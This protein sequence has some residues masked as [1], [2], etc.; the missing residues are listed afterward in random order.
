MRYSILAVYFEIFKGKLKSFQTTRF[1]IGFLWA[2]KPLHPWYTFFI[3]FLYSKGIKRKKKSKTFFP[4]AQSV[5]GSV[6]A[7]NF[8]KACSK[9]YFLHDWCFG[10]F[11]S[12]I[13]K[14]EN[15]FSKLLFLYVNKTE[16]MR[17]RGGDHKKFWIGV[18]KFERRMMGWFLAF[19]F[20]L[21]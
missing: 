16:M 9:P 2:R 4:R 19:V 10:I 6:K 7:T 11:P 12:T 13:F 3:V 14:K 18:E 20:S 5:C 21:E 8:F 15:F 17:K 1:L